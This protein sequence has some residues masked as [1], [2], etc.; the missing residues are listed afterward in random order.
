MV[1]R[2]RIL[3]TLFFLVSAAP[4]FAQFGDAPATKGARNDKA[5]TQKIKVGLNV[6]AGGTIV[7]FT[8]TVPVPFDWPEQQVRIDKEDL[9]PGVQ[10]IEYK[11]LNAGVRQ[12]IVHVPNLPAG[13][14]AHAY[15]TFE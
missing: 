6:T 13:Q 2:N 7:G 5:L 9:S 4:A 15:V 1:M 10:K 8:G 14:E 3:A 12:M 11:I